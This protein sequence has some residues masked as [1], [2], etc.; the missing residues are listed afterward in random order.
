VA[1]DPSAAKWCLS[2]GLRLVGIDYLS[3]EPF[4]SGR[5]GHPVHHALL[6]AE[7]VIVEGL[8]LED[9]EPGPYLVAALP[10]A[11]PGSDGAPARVVL[12][13]GLV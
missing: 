5:H 10:L 9:V 8:D 11:V 6:E 2:R 3:I 4:G 7:I 1:L 12:V 13:E